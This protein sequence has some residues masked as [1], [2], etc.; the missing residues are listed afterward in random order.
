MTV[1]PPALHAHLAAPSLMSMWADLR[2]R[3]ER[4]GH[5]VRGTL[6][7]DLDDAAADKLGGLLGRS[8]ERGTCRVRLAELDGALRTSAAGRGLVSVVAELTGG[9]LRDR[10]AERAKSQAGREKLWAHLDRQLVAVGVAD[11]DWVTP[12]TDWLHRGGMLSRLPQAAAEPTLSMAVRVIAAVL[13]TDRAPRS[14]AELAAEHTGTAHGLD[15]GVPTGALVLRGVAFAVQAPAPTSAAERRALWQRVGVSTDEISGTVLVWALRPPGADRWSTMMRERADL[16]LITHLT[17]HELHHTEPLTPLGE[18]VHACENPQVLQQLAAAG[19]DR[20]LICTSGNPAAVG[21]HLLDRVIV[22]Y[23]GDFDWPG[24]AIAR[25]IIARGAT[26]W[27]LG[28]DDYLEAAARLPA[29]HRLALTGR[30]ESTPW[31]VRLHT[32]MITTDVAV[33]EEAIVDLLLADLRAN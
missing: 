18:V 5:A 22:R 11:Q 30:P 6:V 21:L 28:H 1:L 15:D 20:P 14:L 26:P 9:A 25:R 10:P 13:A 8:L 27:R 32:V 24:I 17:V 12:W 16:G 2:E 3:L 7:V 19:V 4:T 23:H 31:D 29:D 33:H